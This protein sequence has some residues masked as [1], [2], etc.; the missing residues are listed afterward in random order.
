MMK[1]IDIVKDWGQI[2]VEQYF[3][4]T[5]LSMDSYYITKAAARWLKYN[6]IMYIGVIQK[7]RFNTIYLVME[8]RLDKSGTSCI[9]HNSKTV[10]SVAFSWSGNKKLGKKCVYT[11]ACYIRAVRTQNN[12]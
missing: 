5:V 6:Q 10:E 3:K 11:N 12:T 9:A 2:I 4:K 1:C 8:P 7:Q